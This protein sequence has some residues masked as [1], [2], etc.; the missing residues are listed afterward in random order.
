MDDIEKNV[1]ELMNRAQREDQEQRTD[2]MIKMASVLSDKSVAYTNVIFLA[3]Y[4]GFFA[5]WSMMKTSMSRTEMLL[6]AFCIVFSLVVFVFSEIARMIINYVTVRGL[7]KVAQWPPEEFGKRLAKREKAIQ[8]MNIRVFILWTLIWALTI[9]PGLI[10]AGVLL[11]S[12]GRQ[13]WQAA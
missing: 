12:F 10:A 3:G 8:R 1:Q 9:V 7:S 4:A 13:L 2:Y 5:V 6:T 11:W